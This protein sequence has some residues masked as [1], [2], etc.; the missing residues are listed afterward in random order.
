MPKP[1]DR[2]KQKAPHEI[3]W[4]Q[5]EQFARAS[6]RDLTHAFRVFKGERT[7]GALADAFE[8][9]FGFPMNK[10]ALAGRKSAAA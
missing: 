7:S 10:T 3:T 6:G 8:R 5:F 2:R 4:T 9:H 1:T